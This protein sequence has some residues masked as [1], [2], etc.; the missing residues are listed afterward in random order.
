MRITT[1]KLR[2]KAP[3]PP[4]K[5]PLRTSPKPIKP[6]CKDSRVVLKRERFALNCLKAVPVCCPE[7]HLSSVR[8]ATTQSRQ[9]CQGEVLVAATCCHAGVIGTQAIRY[10]SDD[11][12][13]DGDDYYDSHPILVLVLGRTAFCH[14]SPPPPPKFFRFPSTAR[15]PLTGG[16]GPQSGGTSV[17]ESQHWNCWL[18][19]SKE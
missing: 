9:T 18:V 4:S 2:P 13:C 5:L 1:P 14:F 15:M 11:D 12:Y 7:P 3:P 16:K 6:S 10:F 19:L 17:E 8:K